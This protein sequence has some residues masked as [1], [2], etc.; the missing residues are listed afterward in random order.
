MKRSIVLFLVS[1]LATAGV[2]GGIYYAFT[3]NLIPGVG[4]IETI[5]PSTTN[6]E[7]TRN[8]TQYNSGASTETPATTPT[9]DDTP[10]ADSTPLPVVPSEPEIT[11][12][13]IQPDDTTTP[14]PPTEQDTETTAPEPGSTPSNEET[15]APDGPD[16][17]LPNPDSARNEEHRVALLALEAIRHGDLKAALEYLIKRRLMT[18][19]AA[20]VIQTWAANNTPGELVETA[21]SR[22]EDGNKVTRYRVHTTNGS[23]DLILDVVTDRNGEAII[24]NA[25]TAPADK[26]AITA[27]SDHITATEGF[28][29]AV[30]S[31]D[32][33]K[34]CS[35]ITGEEIS[36]AT[37]AGLCMI[38]EEDNFRMREHSPIRNTFVN[39]EFA[40]NLVY[41]TSANPAIT[42][43][44][45]IAIELA[46]T[47]EGWRVKAAGLEGLLLSYENSAVAEGGRYFPI[48]KNPKGGDSIA[49]FFGFNEADLTPRSQRQLQIIAELLKGTN[50]R[51][52]ISGHTD[53]VGSERYN[54][55]LSERRAAA[56][57]EAL[58]GFGASAD[59][60]TTHGLGMSQP[61]RLPTA[62]D[63]EQTIDYIRGEN[64]RAEIYLDFES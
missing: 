51:L 15:T 39:D 12:E 8:E 64:R 22:R 38:F 40:G 21:N 31:G 62:A 27:E 24:E 26:T 43:E 25:T 4:E 54:Q 7:A 14:N 49:L 3:H 20:A 59:Q 57:K 45:R 23:E 17:T 61:R 42:Q 35:L 33:P 60:I 63:T 34:A 18:D 2:G 46:R 29:E 16:F 36:F 19:S 56:V 48:V 55:S 58:V 52:N 10:K 13:P 6:T 9:T 11:E 37:V 1:F 41:L 5:T 50:R 47:P 32:M 53:D 28:F 30:R 44:A